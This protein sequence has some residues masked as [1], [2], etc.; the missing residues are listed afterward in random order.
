M[1]DE[2]DRQFA[3]LAQQYL[4]DRGRRHPELA[5]ELG[6]H[7]FD[8]Q[9]PTQSAAA[10]A[11]ERRA[12][13]RWAEALAGLDTGALTAEHQVDAAMLANDIERQI[14]ELDEL[15]EQTW[16]PLLANPGRAIYQLLA[17]DFAPL[18]ER[19]ASLAGRLAEVPATLTAARDL[20][21]PMPRVHLETAIGQFSGTINLITTVLEAA[22]AAAPDAGRQ[23]QD[24]AGAREAALA[25]VTEHRA[26]L[27]ARLE[28]TPAD[29]FADPRLGAKRFAR[30]LSL[31]L[32]AQADADAILARAHADLD[33]VSQEISAVA[34][35][36]AGTAGPGRDGATAAGGDP[37]VRQVLDRLAADAP[38]DQTILDFGRRALTQQTA[39]VAAHELVTLFDDPVEVIEMPEIDR[40]V[41]VA[42]C[43][44]PGPLEPTPMA[45]FVAVSPTPADWPAERVASFYREYNRHMVHN[46]M[47]HEA[48][49]GHYLQLQHSRR[50]TGATRLRAALWSGPFVEGW[51][52]Y[53][54]E[55]MARHEY[56]GE[57]D[58]AAVR[59]Q[60]LKMQLRMVI[61]AILDARVHARGM[62]EAEAMTLMTA[63]GFQEDGEASGK[64]RRAQLTSAQLSTYYVGYTEVADLAADLR[65]R[66]LSE[67]AA[68]DSMLAHGSPPARLLRELL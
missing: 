52:V 16:N 30:K 2:N 55:L 34:A 41:A 8:A 28:D 35:D 66:G 5:T 44:P 67:R 33:R 9:L 47:V 25:A 54:E 26:W 10:L 3:T 59:M 22:L 61:N 23:G 14:F 29:G 38:D 68:H 11:A 64:W 6:D 27:E 4:D 51:A 45:T 7:R 39:F 43:D 62:T 42:Y 13:S 49:P 31:A 32:N 12:L 57:G 18:P 48:M 46:L 37:V 63:R 40:G 24:L 56:P 19:L 36:I 21:G 58:P 20:L 60:Q 53:A 1:T 50:F 65:R 15:H 17:R